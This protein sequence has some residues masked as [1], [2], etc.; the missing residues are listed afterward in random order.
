M[1]E[2]RE[3]MGASCGPG[4]RAGTEPQSP[5][6]LGPTPSRGGSPEAAYW[7]GRCEGLLEGLRLTYTPEQLAEMGFV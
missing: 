1:A 2:N 6:R 3:D 5:Q 7:R 4:S